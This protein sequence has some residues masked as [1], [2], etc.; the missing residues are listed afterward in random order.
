MDASPLWYKNA[1]IYELHVKSFCDGNNDGIGDFCGMISK[2]D[3]LQN[4][5]I[6]AIWLLPFY[7]SPGKDDGY[8]IVD[9]CGVNPD[10]GT[11]DDFRTLLT[12]AHNRN[13]RIIIELIINHTS[14]QHPWFI[15]ARNSPP[16]SPA[17]EFYV[18]S[19]TESK[20]AQT[21]IIFTDTEKSN[22]AWD[23]VAKAYYWHRFFS[24][25]PDLN[26]N[27]PRVVDAVIDV[28]K[29]WLDMGVD[30]LRLDA[31]PYLCVQEGTNN[32]NIPQTHAVI[33]QLRRE[34][35]RHYQQRVLI[36][37]ANQWPQDLLPYFGNGD[38]C[39]MAFHFPIMPRIYTALRRE[40]RTPI[41]DILKRTP[42]IPDS[43][44]W[45]MFLRNHDELTLEMVTDEER[46]YMYAEYA[47]EPRMR[48]NVGIRRRL[49]PLVNN[50]PRIIEM[51]HALILSMPGTPIIYYGDEIGMG[52]NIYLKDRDGVRTPMQWADQCNAGF[53]M[54]QPERLYSQPIR[55]AVFGYRRVNV[56]AQEQDPTSLLK[57]MRRL[58][59]M[60]KHYQAFGCGNLQFLFPQN[61]KILAYLRC[62]R[63]QKLL[64]VINLS[65]A[66]QSVSLDLQQFAGCTLTE[67]FGASKFPTIGHLPYSLTLDAYSYYWFAL[68]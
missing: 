1:I 18:W 8:D 28:M 6:D 20:F 16:G 27:N 14:D 61:C 66:A 46:A 34:V 57:S 64:V 12:E 59:T 23:P 10:Y 4:L 25:Q 40:D 19:D 44:Q 13:I 58:I 53:S 11:L 48:I 42:A 51:L 65:Q 15:E 21:R 55:N 56:D 17:R 41:I 68:L 33:K 37:E 7:P 39:H 49:A 32:E 3:Y 63:E 47:P 9:Y 24:H 38:E 54:A 5:G 50:N 62:Y 31:I 26:H 36:A 67:I 35:D 60:R 45:A 22:W 43:C 2:L 30:G 52:D 29:F